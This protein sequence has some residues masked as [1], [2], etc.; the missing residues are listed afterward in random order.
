MKILSFSIILFEYVPCTYKKHADSYAILVLKIEVPGEVVDVKI[1]KFL[2]SV[3][4]NFKSVP[5][6]LKDKQ[7]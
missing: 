2:Q 5:T 7:A 1:V 3:S 6:Y 4:S